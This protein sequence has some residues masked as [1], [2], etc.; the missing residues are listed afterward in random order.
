[1]RGRRMMLVGAG[2][3]L[4][5]STA[6]WG[7][8]YKWVDADGQVHYGE[9]APQ[10]GGSEQVQVEQGPAPDAAAAARRAK[11]QKFMRALEEDRQVR[12]SAQ[13]KA[14][15]KAEQREHRCALARDR[16]RTYQRSNRVYRLDSQGKRVYLPDSS[17]DQAIS[18]ARQEI[19]RWCD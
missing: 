14:E 2:L 5:V 11:Q 4:A 12:E 10:T 17:R 16:L 13:Q 3:L 18:R 9:R 7:G 15:Q 19:Q 6:A 8:I 1:M